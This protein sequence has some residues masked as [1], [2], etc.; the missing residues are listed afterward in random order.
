MFPFPFE[1][2]KNIMVNDWSTLIG[3]PFK[4]ST[5]KWPSIPNSDQ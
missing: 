5:D 3:E 2:M 4:Y 1:K